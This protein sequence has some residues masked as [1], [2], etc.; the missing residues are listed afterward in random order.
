[1][2]NQIA[3]VQDIVKQQLSREDSRKTWNDKLLNEKWVFLFENMESD[4]PEQFAD[5]YKI[6]EYIYIF[7]AGT[8]W[9]FGDNFFANGNTMD[10]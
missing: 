4:V 10:R 1:L 5:I 6:C 3:V 2:F 7:C 8:Q 9:K